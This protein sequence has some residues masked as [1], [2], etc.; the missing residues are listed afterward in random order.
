MNQD[1]AEAV[2]ELKRAFRHSDIT[3]SDDGQGG[4]YVIVESM[5]IG[6][7]FEPPV[8]WMG[9]HISSLYP[10]ADIYPVFIGSDVRRADGR[11]FA[12]P[13]TRGHHFAGRSAIQ[14]SRRNNQIHLA[15]QS[16]LAKFAK[17]LDFLDRLP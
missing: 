13:V 10:A 14:I 4:A 11:E 15:P 7:R 2:E 12:A 8:T 16:A 5:P 1:V 9:G 3:V 6:S 17:V